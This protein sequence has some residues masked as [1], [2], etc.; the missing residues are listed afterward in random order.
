MMKE[1]VSAM[2]MTMAGILKRLKKNAA[3]FDITN[4][5]AKATA[6]KELSSLIERKQFD[7]IKGK[8]ELTLE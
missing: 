3:L 2:N 8:I 4:D 6:C 7:Q 1:D 5:T